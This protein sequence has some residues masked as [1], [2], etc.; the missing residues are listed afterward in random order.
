MEDWV[1]L[2]LVFI[3]G[4]LVVTLVAILISQR[5][6]ANVRL[7]GRAEFFIEVD[8]G[9]RR[10]PGGD[11][12]S[13]PPRQSGPPKAGGAARRPS[14]RTWLAAKVRGG[15]DWVFPLDGRQRVF[16]G[17]HED[18]DLVLR[19]PTAATR[20]A[21]IYWEDGRYRINNLSTDRPT[22][23]NNRPISWQNLGDGN[24]ILMG[25]T[26]LIFRQKKGPT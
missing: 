21:V 16:I 23:V 17:R 5:T 7:P 20:Q 12:P 25:R 15:P 8:K 19:D 26:K 2:F 6:Q 1:L 13:K 24:T 3:V 10:A 4:A 14:Y 18:N 9:W 22:Q 11:R